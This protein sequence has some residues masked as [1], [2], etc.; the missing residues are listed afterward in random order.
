M[1]FYYKF[2]KKFEE[3]IKKEFFGRLL[4]KNLILFW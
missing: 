1:I 2:G 4:N 3:M